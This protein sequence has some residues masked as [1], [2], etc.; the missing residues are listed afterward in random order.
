[1]IIGVGQIRSGNFPAEAQMI[2]QAPLGLE[3]G[4]DIA[5]AFPIS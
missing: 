4:D 1:M 2:E 5:E 3:T